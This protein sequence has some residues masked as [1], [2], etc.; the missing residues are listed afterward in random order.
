MAD[1]KTMTDKNPSFFFPLY[2][3]SG[4]GGEKEERGKRKNNELMLRSSVV[5]QVSKPA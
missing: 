1:G 4:T 2:L 3:S 5:P